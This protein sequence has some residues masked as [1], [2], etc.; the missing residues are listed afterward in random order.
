MSGPELAH[1]MGVTPQAVHELEKSEARETIRLETLERVADALG[2]D[3]E[4]VLVPRESLQ[5]M[6]EAQARRKA[7]RFIDPIAHHS[8]LEDQMLAE[9][10][11]DAQVE[12]L[13][14]GFI[15]RRGLWSEDAAP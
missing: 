12:D 7:I 10:A 8:R 11:V 5:D 3:L 6:V 1:R 13:G 9:D 15:D 4:Y 2:C 14:L